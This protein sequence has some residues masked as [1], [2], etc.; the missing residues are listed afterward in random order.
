[1]ILQEKIEV[2]PGIFYPVPRSTPDRPIE[3][4]FAD[5]PRA[6]QYWRRQEDFPQYFYDYDPHQPDKKVC[7]INASRTEYRHGK[8]VTLSVEDTIELVRLVKR[9]ADRMRNGVFIMNNGTRIY[10]PGFYYGAL[11]WGK[12]FGVSDNNGYGQHRR[13]QREY[14]YSRQL[15]IQEDALDGYYCHKIKKSGLTNLL[16]LFYVIEAITNKQ[17]TAAMMSKN[18]ETAKKANYKYFLYGYK[19]LLPVL[20]PGIEQKGWSNSVQKL[21]IRCSDA[22][23]NLENTVAAVPTTTDGLDGLPPIQRIFIDEPPK[24]TDIEEVYT[25][26]KEQ[27]RIQQVKIGIIEMISYPPENDGKAFF[28]CKDFYQKGCEKRGEDGWPLNRMLPVYIGIAEAT[29]G[30]ID[31]YGEPNRLLALQ[32]EQ[33]KRAECKNSNELQARKRQYHVSAREGWESGGSGTVYNNIILGEQEAKLEE[34]Y[35][36]GQL[37]YVEGNIEWTAGRFSPPRF[38]QLLHEEI[39]KGATG[40]WKIYCERDNLQAFLE[41]RTNKCFK[42][43]RKKKLIRKEIV[44]LL[45]PPDDE[46]NVAGGDPVDYAYKSETTGKISKNAMVIK[47]IMGNLLAEFHNRSEDPDDDIEEFIKGMVFFGVRAIIEGNRKNAVTM[48]ENQGLYFFMLIRH[49]NG[50][51]VPYGQGMSIKHVSSGKDLKSLY[52]GLIMKKIKNNISQFKSIATIKQHKEFDPVHTQE[53]DLAVADGLAEV[54][55]DAVQTWVLS[56]KN[57]VNSYEQ[58]AMAMRTV[59]G[60]GA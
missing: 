6:Q 10:F 51:I 31:V 26:S 33:N 50:E 53:F 39:M 58:L 19:N 13:Y 27:N 38:D 35:N 17:F 56:K 60:V 32:M 11:Q 21:E 23:M 4:L 41:R 37:N 29:K 28:W 43:P 54:A 24:I 9:E 20:R 8:L 22:D 49:V 47:D 7:R 52:I 59:Y 55:L 46:H 16:A 44:L 25:K 12:M 57:K 3:T 15:A 45:Q 48:L 34:E 2:A 30:T 1:M 42:M 36:F 40:K 14:A 5:L 18:H